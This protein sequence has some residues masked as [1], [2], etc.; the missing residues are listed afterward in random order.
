MLASSTSRRLTVGK[1][2]GLTLTIYRTHAGPLLRTAAIFL[3]P[4]AVLSFF[5]VDDTLTSILLSFI[6]WPITAIANLSLISL[7]NEL[8]HGRPLAVRAAVGQ[9]LR[10]LLAYLG[11]AIAESS[12]YLVLL[13]LLAF[14][15][16]YGLD[17]T[18]L[19]FNELRHRFT[20]MLDQGEANSLFTLLAEAVPVGLAY[21]SLG[22]VVLILFFYLSSRWL[23]AQAAF[24]VED[25]GPLDSLGRSWHLSHGFVMRT[26][27]Y[28]ILLT[29]LMGL[30]GG[31]AGQFIEF[32]LARLIPA[33]DQSS[34]LGLSSAITN[35]LSILTT[36]FYICAVVLYYFDLRARK[37]KYSWQDTH[38]NLD[39]H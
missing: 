26:M 14:P 5:F 4:L 3:F 16:L 20:E 36:P 24:M 38:D 39:S 7:C 32:A 29:I 18:A 21:C 2:L 37:E 17:S 1:W 34:R 12:V 30:V 25:T 8:L 9:G 28:V 31:L 15:V 22:I 33:I 11:L 19:D 6:F 13:L 10:R 27:G 35:L 23:V